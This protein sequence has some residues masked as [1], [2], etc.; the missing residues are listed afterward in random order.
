[1]NS[2]LLSPKQIHAFYMALLLVGSRDMVARETTLPD[3]RKSL[4]NVEVRLKAAYVSDFFPT[5]RPPLLT[6]RRHTS[7]ST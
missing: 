1:M 3:N 2:Y 6:Q 4:T 7:N 5:I